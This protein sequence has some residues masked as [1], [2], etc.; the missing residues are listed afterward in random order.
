MSPSQGRVQVEA[1]PSMSSPTLVTALFCTVRSLGAAV[2][3]PRSAH[4][5]FVGCGHSFSPVVRSC[6]IS[7]F[8]LRRCYE[9]QGVWLTSLL[10]PAHTRLPLLATQPLSPSSASAAGF[11]FPFPCTAQIMGLRLGGGWEVTKFRL[12]KS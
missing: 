9:N 8:H 2:P 10:A 5:L 12:T 1:W 6:W 11:R 4:T 3:M 7:P